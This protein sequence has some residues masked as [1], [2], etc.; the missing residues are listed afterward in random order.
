MSIVADLVSLT[1]QLIAVYFNCYKGH[2]SCFFYN[3]FRGHNKIVCRS[4][5]EIFCTRMDSTKEYNVSRFRGRQK[6]RKRV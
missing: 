6:L 2:K 5:Y 4:D 1:A 3:M